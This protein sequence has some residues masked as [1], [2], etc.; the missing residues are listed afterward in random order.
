MCEREANEIQRIVDDNKDNL[1]QFILSDVEPLFIDVTFR[2]ISEYDKMDIHMHPF[3]VT[4]DPI[5]SEITARARVE[6]K[7]GGQLRFR[8]MVLVARQCM[9]GEAFRDN[10]YIR[11]LKHYWKMIS[12]N[13]TTEPYVES[14]NGTISYI[15]Y[16]S[17]AAT[18]G[19]VLLHAATISHQL[20]FT[21]RYFTYFK[22][23]YTLDYAY[24]SLVNYI[25]K[26]PWTNTI[27]VKKKTSLAKNMTHA[28]TPIGVGQVIMW[29]EGS[30]LRNYTV[31]PTTANDESAYAIA[32]EA[33]KEDFQSLK[34]EGLIPLSQWY[35]SMI[36][37]E[38]NP[39]NMAQ[40]SLLSFIE[41][42]AGFFRG[43][44]L[45]SHIKQKEAG[46]Q[47]ATPKNPPFAQNIRD[48][49]INAIKEY[50]FLVPSYSEYKA[51]IF[52]DLT[53][54]SSG[55]YGE[56]WEIPSR[57]GISRHFTTN[58]KIMAFIRNTSKYLDPETVKLEMTE[59]FPAPIFSREVVARDKRAVFAVPLGTYIVELI[60]SNVFM[61]SQLKSNLF[62][63]GKEVGQTL[64]DHKEGIIASCQPYVLI[65]GQ[66]FSAFDSTQKFDNM[67]RFA[68][69]G[70]TRGLIVNGQTGR[71][72]PWESIS[73]AYDMIWRKTKTA[74]YE[75][76]G[77][78]LVT[79]QV[80]SGEKNTITI[81]NFTN[82]ANFETQ[83]REL[84]INPKTSL[85]FT[86][87]DIMKALFMGDDS[88]QLWRLSQRL[89][90]EQLKDIKDVLSE[91]AAA[92]GM[93]LNALKTEAR[94]FHYEY[95][96]KRAD[97]GYIIPRILQLQQFV[98]ERVNTLLAVNEFMSSYGNLLNEGVSRGYSH[99]FAR[100]LYFF[101]GNLRR[102]VKV[103]DRV[104]NYFERLPLA[105]LFTP[106]NMGGTGQVP[107]SMI[108]AN[109]DITFPL[110][111]DGVILEMMN[112]ALWLNDAPSEL[113]IRDRIAEAIIKGT[114]Q[115]NDGLEFL[116]VNKD[117]ERGETASA[118]L[119]FLA[120]K[121]IDLGSVSK[122]NEHN[123][124]IFATIKDN[125]RMNQ[126]VA[127]ER[128]LLADEVKKKKAILDSN[129]KMKFPVINILIKDTSTIMEI[130]MRSTNDRIRVVSWWRAIRRT[131][132]SGMELDPDTI[133]EFLSR[134]LEVVTRSGRR[135]V[136][137]SKRKLVDDAMNMYKEDAA[138]VASFI[139]AIKGGSA[140][141]VPRMIED[142]YRWLRPFAIK[143][144]KP[145]DFVIPEE[146][147]FPL[148]GMDPNIE[149]M[150]RRIGI[151][152]Q[153]DDLAVAANR[154][155]SE[156]VAD[157]KFPRDLT[158][159]KIFSIISRPDISRDITHISAALRAMGASTSA[160]ASV[161]EKFA[162]ISAQFTF[163][164]RTS[165]YSTRD[166]VMG[167]LDLSISNYRR[168]CDQDYPIGIMF[169]NL[170]VSVGAIAT[171]TD[172]P[173]IA[174]R[175]V[176][177]KIFGEQVMESRSD[178]MGKGFNKVNLFWSGFGKSILK[179]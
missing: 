133:A 33:L 36:S 45:P 147:A 61:I 10:Q 75:S 70:V 162:R 90:P 54:K 78:I 106:S 56:Q 35:A 161:A 100:S 77:E 122:L 83:L 51:T 136:I 143:W 18:R 126:I 23:Q 71:F 20:N 11:K 26:D 82:L 84:A 9:G 73:S 46:E 111:F 153:G 63:M 159:E 138:T 140:N 158:A 118:A 19:L 79:D 80:N 110:T 30:E 4:K 92:N 14:F 13:F 116:R 37:A 172:M 66:D 132:Q 91:V 5:W 115:T 7:I 165:S 87:M 59:A 39:E 97:Y 176:T 96:K 98:S 139:D 128:G 113:R 22:K 123:R 86:Y 175:H 72:G 42:P 137:L 43:N 1:I 15:T 108:G 16:D 65:I 58:D 124:M 89:T 12:N 67:R 129:A 85:T 145:V 119:D 32:E 127:E 3:K 49:Y 169:D 76:N 150:M 155:L 99:A 109:K 69:E 8:N 160:A 2:D 94:L 152:S 154:L 107:M 141:L 151:S 170:V 48:L 112:Q 120:S 157:R 149:Q 53:T 41:T 24:S 104:K 131:V 17:M 47:T 55:G 168:I 74:F 174:T 130:I 57:N 105:I 81:N 25:F 164:D 179:Q 156:I 27:N 103:K 142:E 102:S 166:K 68:L 95:L 125:P 29:A 144:D 6:T 34:D 28:I 146:K 21:T 60:L 44:E 31:L 38:V 148:A 40:V 163:L 114:D 177:M 64:A 171:I 135:L 178:L 88:V 93:S 167:H 50:K 117:K 121:G 134:M 101:T 52:N 62:T 173:E